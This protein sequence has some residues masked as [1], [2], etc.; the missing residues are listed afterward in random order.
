MHYTELGNTGL[1]VSVAGLGTGGFSK[2]G[3]SAGAT[4]EEAAD[5]VRVALDEGINF[6]DTAAVYGTQPAVGL[7]LK[8]RARE[9]IVIST[10]VEISRGTETRPLGDIVASL[11]N[12]LSELGVDHVDIFHLHAVKPMHYEYALNEVVPLLAQEQAKG[13]FAHLG[14]TESSP[15]DLEH[16]TLRRALAEQAPFR[17]MMLGHNMMHQSAERDLYPETQAQGIGTLVMFAVRRIFANPQ[18]LSDEISR[19]IAAGE[20]D[21]SEVDVNDPVG[22]LVHEAGASN[23]IEAAYRYCRHEAGADVVLFG[24]GN[25]QHVKSNIEALNLPALPASDVA[26][27]KRRFGSLVGVGIELPNP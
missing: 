7:A 26:E 22:F 9:D 17:V 13:K 27:L 2:I 14:I 19:R 6:I 11:D 23:V 4:D 21:A 15:N 24:T 12:S 3:L 8:G 25:A 18:M 5:V 20:L 10:K 1:K 16:V